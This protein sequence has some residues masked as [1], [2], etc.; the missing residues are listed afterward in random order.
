MLGGVGVW[1]VMRGGDTVPADAQAAAIES[2]EVERTTSAPE[3]TTSST[4]TSS[5]A[6]TIPAEYEI[7]GIFTLVDSDVE[8][9]GYLCWGT[10]GYDDVA[11]GMNVTVRDGNDVIIGVGSTDNVTREDRTSLDPWLADVATGVANE[12]YPNVVCTLVFKVSVPD[13]EFYSVEVGHRGEL[14]YS[15]AEME[16]A[17]WAVALTL[18]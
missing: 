12:R 1:L 8:R 3:T 15:R 16:A 18:D 4:T 9:D 5:G 14:N 10:G 6:T 13:A 11:A 2:T 17:D 7:R